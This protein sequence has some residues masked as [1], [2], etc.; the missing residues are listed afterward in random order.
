MT[1]G[2]EHPARKEKGDNDEDIGRSATLPTPRDDP[3]GALAAEDPAPGAALPSG[4]RGRDEAPE[5]PAPKVSMD[6]LAR[7]PS[8]AMV[9]LP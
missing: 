6:G 4:Y 7:K 1:A 2:P 9:L 5:P 3:H 8:G